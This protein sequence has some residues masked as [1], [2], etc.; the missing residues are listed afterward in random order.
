VTG[1]ALAGAGTKRRKAWKPPTACSSASAWPSRTPSM[2]TP[3]AP[4]WGM[5]T[6]SIRRTMSADSIRPP[7]TRNAC[8]SS[9]NMVRS[10]RPQNSALRSLTYWKTL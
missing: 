3:S 7:A 5:A 10:V 9:R 8:A 2:P 1:P 4:G 6:R